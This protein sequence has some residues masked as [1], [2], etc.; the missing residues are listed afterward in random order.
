MKRNSRTC[1]AQCDLRLK[2]V[3]TKC[4]ITYALGRLVFE[5]HASPSSGERY[6]KWRRR[7]RLV[8]AD[9]IGVENDRLE[10]DTRFSDSGKDSIVLQE[11]PRGYFT[12]AVLSTAVVMTSSCQ[13][14]P[15]FTSDLGVT[16]NVAMRCCCR[17][18]N[19]LPCGRRPV[20]QEQPE[21]YGNR[22]LRACHFANKISWV[23]QTT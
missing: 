3:S 13:W 20:Q 8:V 7:G 4:Y 23:I 22:G 14:G 16:L 18:R 6:L 9:A 19:T 21:Y 17:R 2:I 10:T 15:V 11:V 1:S 5:I 12:A